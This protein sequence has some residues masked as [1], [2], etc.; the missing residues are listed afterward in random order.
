M[1]IRLLKL[2]FLLKLFVSCTEVEVD[3]Y[4]TEAYFQLVDSLRIELPIEHSFSTYNQHYKRGDTNFLMLNS[5]NQKCLIEIDID[6]Q[7]VSRIIP[8]KFIKKDF[9]PI[10]LF[11][12]HNNDSI[13]ILRDVSNLDR[14]YHD[15]LLAIINNQ[16]DLISFVNL[17]GGTFLYHE[18][19]TYDSSTSYFGHE[20]ENFNIAENRLFITPNPAFFEDIKSAENNGVP[21]LGYVDFNNENQGFIRIPISISETLFREGNYS[22]DQKL[23]TKARAINKNSIVVSLQGNRKLIIADTLGNILHEPKNMYHLIDD[24]YELAAG[25]ENKIY[26]NPNS[27]VFSNIIIDHQNKYIVRFATLPV[28]KGLSESEYAE[29]NYS[30]QWFGVYDFKLNL[31]AEGMKPLRFYTSLPIPGYMDSLFVRA[32]RNKNNH[33]ELDIYFYELNFKRSNQKRVEELK[34]LEDDIKPI[35]TLSQYF[36]KFSLPKGSVVLLI[37]SL[38]CPYCMKNSMQYYFDNFEFMKKNEIY[39]FCEHEIGESYPSLKKVNSAYVNFEDNKELRNYYSK[40]IRNPVLLYWNGSNIE[41][42]VI[43]YPDKVD[44]LSFVIKE[45]INLRL[46]KASP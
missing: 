16:G 4:F 31:I 17:R 42:E 2:V 37:P 46:D 20:L 45:F 24:A 13:L 32:N 34:E 30:H 21:S 19:E 23:N 39:L 6:H 3:N 27:P 15:S 5:V 14:P 7:I 26:R 38:S 41:S 28:P 35:K 36:Q 25:V 9:Y 18:D 11:H 8:V 33:Y 43:L 44:S 22:I 12:Y 1:T 29:F 40:E 10:F